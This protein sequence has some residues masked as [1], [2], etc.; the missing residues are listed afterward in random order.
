M[1]EEG[2]SVLQQFIDEEI[3]K[4]LAKQLNS[5]IEGLE[6]PTKDRIREFILSTKGKQ[7][8]PALIAVTTKLL[9]Q[10]TESQESRLARAYKF[11]IVIELLHNMTLIHDDLI[12][13]A[14]I[15]RGKDAFH[16]RHGT[17]RALHDVDVLHA[18]ALTLI[19]DDPAGLKLVLDYAY[20]VGLGNAIELEDR[21]DQNFDFEMSRVIKIMEY[22]T[23]VVFAGCVRLG[24]LAANREDLFTEALNK[25]IIAAG[26]AFQIQDDYLDILG[27]P[28]EFGKMQFWDIQESKRNLFLHFSMRTEHSTKIKEIYNK[29]IGQKNKE[30]IDI[31][32]K[33]FQSIQEKV[34]EVRDQYA[35]LAIDGLK[36][37]QANINKDDYQAEELIDFLLILSKYLIER[38][39]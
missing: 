16:I 28:E 27:N 9:I 11:A 14:P 25:A 4:N 32:L 26:I 33:V 29:D 10:D 18:Y 8:R 19:K 1:N 36:S 31:V 34:K 3:T 35:K 17:D 30:D 37:I 12:D 24:C 20:Q 5:A 23:A 13:N 15:R 7:L 39:K 22:K 2:I 38:S 21:L 6:S